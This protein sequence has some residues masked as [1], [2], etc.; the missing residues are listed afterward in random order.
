MAA[1][2][3][4]HSPETMFKRTDLHSAAKA[5]EKILKNS[6]HRFNVGYEELIKSLMEPKTE[7]KAV[8]TI[9]KGVARRFKVDYEQL[10]KT[11][12]EKIREKY[13]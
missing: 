2:R 12:A 11:M 13:A 10:I 1:V 6:L 9:L 3:D 8:E 7:Y 5:A 4:L